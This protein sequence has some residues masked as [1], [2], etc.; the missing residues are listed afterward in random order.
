MRNF[1]RPIA[2][3]SL[4]FLV[5]IGAAHA[6]AFNF[7]VTFNGT[8]ATVDGTS[9]PVAGTS[10]SPG[11][12]FNLD[13]HAAANDHWS[14]TSNVSGSIDSSFFVQ[15]SGNR[16]G[17]ATT[18]LYLD[19]VQV[20]QN[21]LNGLIQAS[22]HIGG[23]Q[24]NFTAGTLFDQLV[25][26]YSFLSTTS[27]FTTIQAAANVI[28]FSPFFRNENIAYVA[29]PVVNSVPEPTTLALLGAGLT[30]LGWARRKQA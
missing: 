11:D 2:A 8:S 23:Q 3:L 13:I 7:D 1:L 12:T 17:N 14:V 25:V 4:A 19:G 29:G 5:P 16:V 9:D 20:A 15:D 24:F 18:T 22:V 28:E 10:L 27:T 26:D 21:I 30:G 6:A